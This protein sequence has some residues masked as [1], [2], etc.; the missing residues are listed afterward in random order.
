M[1]IPHRL[2]NSVQDIVVVAVT[3]LL[4]RYPPANY[5]YRTLRAYK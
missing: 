2:Y 5:R 3:D 1:D 4:G